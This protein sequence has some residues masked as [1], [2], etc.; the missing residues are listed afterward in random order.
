M[1]VN[2]QA[3]DYGKVKLF[4]C[5]D[6]PKTRAVIGK[7]ILYWISYWK[8]KIL[9]HM[10]IRV[11]AA[12]VLFIFMS[13]SSKNEETIVFWISGF[14]PVCDMGAGNT[15]CLFISK[16]DN[17]QQENWE[18]FYSAIEGFEFEEGFLKKVKVLVTA[19]D[20]A[21]AA[22]QSAMRY[23]LVKEL[24]KTEDSRVLLARDWELESMADQTLQTNHPTPSLTFNLSGMQINGNAGCNT[25]TGN[26]KELGLERIT[27]DNLLNTLRI[28]EAQSVE[29]SY[30]S[31]IHEVKS[32]K[33]KNDKLYLLDK[34]G[35]LKL[36]FTQMTKT[37]HRI[38][39]NDIWAA[40]RIE[41]YPINR[42]VTVPG[43]EVNTTEMK[44]Y[45]NDGCND[46]FG[47]VKD[48]TETAFTIENIGPTRKM[49]P[50]MEIPERYKQALLKVRTYTFNERILILNDDNG[51]EVLAFMKV[52]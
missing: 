29:D 50:D 24:D 8:T 16:T 9:N 22:D 6:K 21:V 27:F 3:N 23:T 1:G 45:G 19:Q 11:I 34:D 14:K 38:R 42:M 31:A 5:A 17:L 25:Y 49:C 36:T 47:T 28:C 51:N 41:G 20:D 7:T 13:C 46:Y 39:I 12:F 33:V 4:K 30:F 18:L 44:I 32:F 35:T 48:L 52:D 26:I 43:L 2:E 15:N 10:K 40:V 37:K